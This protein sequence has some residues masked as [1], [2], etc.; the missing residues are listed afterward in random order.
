MKLLPK[1]PS[2]NS[3]EGEVIVPKG[4]A[5]KKAQKAHCFNEEWRRY[6]EA[7]FKTGQESSITIDQDVVQKKYREQE[8][9]MKRGYSEY[10]NFRQLNKLLLFSFRWPSR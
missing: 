2:T 4:R 1:S 8:D 5:L 9:P 7:K 6:L 3:A 10:P